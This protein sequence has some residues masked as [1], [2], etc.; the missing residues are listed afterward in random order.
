M[1]VSTIAAAAAALIMVSPAL[2]T[3]I[4]TAPGN[5]AYVNRPTKGSRDLSEA[6]LLLRDLPDLEARSYE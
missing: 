3:P 6:T 5:G 4:R 2:A 1:R